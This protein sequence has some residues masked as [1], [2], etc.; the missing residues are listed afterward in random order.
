M[1]G[2]QP[3]IGSVLS[4]WWTSGQLQS[5]ED[6][7]ITTKVFHQPAPGFGLAANHQINLESMTPEDVT[8]LTEEHIEQCLKE[9]GV[10]YIDVMLMHWPSIEGQSEEI[11][12]KRRLAAWRVLEVF[13]ERGWLR[14]IGVSNFNEHHLE[15]LMQDGAKIR[16]MLN[17]FE[18]SPYLQFDRIVEYCQKN[19]ILVQSYSPMGSGKNDVKDNMLLKEVA[20]KYQKDVGQIA[21]RYL[22][23][24]GY[25]VS[26]LTNSANRMVSNQEVF[27]F[28]LSDQEM[29]KIDGLNRADGSWGLPSPY[30]LP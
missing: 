21:F 5:R 27:D 30:D 29:A 13:Y 15:Q 8:K 16:P 12:R 22:I 1:Y 28:E 3:Q 11:S 14:A 23:Q 19:D 9:L 2:S 17:Q 25:A 24:K 18:A 7:F 10:G 6:V 4:K 20:K 26:Y